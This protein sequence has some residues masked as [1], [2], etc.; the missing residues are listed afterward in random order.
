VPYRRFQS[1]WWLHILL[2]LLTVATTSNVGRAYY[3]SYLLGPLATGATA[4]HVSLLQGLTFSAA[5]LGILGAH[6]MGH[7]LACRYY[8]VD[9]TLP[10]FLPF[11][12]LSISGTL[13]AVIKIRQMFPNRKALFDIGIA[14][15]IAGFVVLVPILFVAVQH[16]TVVQVAAAPPGT[17][18]FG[19]P[20]L[21]KAFFW[22]RFGALADNYDVN[23][24]PIGF[25]AW[26]GMLATAWNL[27]PFG[28]LDGGHLTYATLGDRSRHISLVT[29]AGAVVMCFVSVNWVVMTMMMVAMLYFLGPRHPRVVDEY[30]PLGRGR[31]ALAIFAA[32]MFALCFTPVPL[33]F[34]P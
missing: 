12:F 5:I 16:S 8:D 4:V 17:L 7:Y 11:P 23:L 26:F 13:G 31:I 18:Y 32:V 25:A 19:E 1:R 29:V 21:L 10:F 6:E 34:Q 24:H 33:K 27:L 2:F 22:L 9:C 28:Q 30:E 20:L 15:P 14:G 3:A